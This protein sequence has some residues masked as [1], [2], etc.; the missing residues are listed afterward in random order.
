MAALIVLSHGLVFLLPPNTFSL[1]INY[2]LMASIAPEWAW[3][4][5]FLALVLIWGYA[6]LR[7]VFRLRQVM[8]SVLGVVILWM[9]VSFFLSNVNT[10]IGYTLIIVGG[11]TLAARVGL[12]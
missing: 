8:L 3:G 5:A 9:G 1:S 10:T 11:G 7:R 12:R 4:G 2:R 6:Q